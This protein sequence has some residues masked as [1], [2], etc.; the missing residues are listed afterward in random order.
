M[1]LSAGVPSKTHI[2]NLLHRL[3]DRKAPMISPI[4]APLALVLA[5]EPRAMRTLRHAMREAR[6]S[7]DPAS[8][9]IVT[10]CAA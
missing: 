8:A 6:N 7:H 2:L 10:C 4:D 3:V 9:A 5:K 1:A